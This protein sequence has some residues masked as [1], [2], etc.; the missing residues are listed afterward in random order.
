VNT[1]LV[2]CEG[3]ICR[4][5][6]AEALLARALPAVQVVSG[7]L[8]ALAG[9]PADEMAVRLMR[10]QGIDISGHRAIQVTREMC[11]KSDIILVMETVQ[12]HRLEEKYPQANGRIYRLCEFT[13]RDVPDPYRQTEAAF[14]EALELIEAGCEQW[15][16]RIRKL[17]PFAA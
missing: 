10:R 6:M 12:R 7:G 5:P 3:N 16:Q 1:I 14:E 11:L 8:G 9:Q 15:L 4:S 2:L 13:K 17:S